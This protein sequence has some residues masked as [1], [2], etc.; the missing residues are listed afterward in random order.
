VRF[1]DR[2]H[3]ARF[4]Q[5]LFQRL[6]A[7]RKLSPVRNRILVTAFRSPRPAAPLSASAPGSMLPA[8]NF[9]SATRASTARSASRLHRLGQFALTKAA[10]SPR[11]RC[12]IR[13]ACY[14]PSRKP[15]LPIGALAP[16][17]INAQSP[18]S[19]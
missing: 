4:P 8:C 12:R 13:A 16:L 9:R 14:P 19:R 15:S 7:R 1:A 10:S 2:L 11:A 18:S 6:P 5:A 3:K 17:R